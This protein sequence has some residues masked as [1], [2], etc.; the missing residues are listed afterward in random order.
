MILYLLFLPLFVVIFNN[1]DNYIDYLCKEYFS[2]R[3]DVQI[4]RAV[5]CRGLAIIQ[6]LD[7]N[8]N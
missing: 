1:A 6:K 5:N 8:H 4:E 7:N 2:D 3:N